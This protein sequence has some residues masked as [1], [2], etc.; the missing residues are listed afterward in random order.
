[1]II[2]EVSI[3][4]AVSTIAILRYE[5]KYPKMDKGFN[6]ASGKHYCNVVKYYN[7]IGFS[8]VVSIPQAVS[9]IAILW[10]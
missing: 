2:R 9:T 10:Y 1:M 3:P 5:E 4:Q 8:N 6:T 7:G